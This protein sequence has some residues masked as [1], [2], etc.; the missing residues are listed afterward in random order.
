MRRWYLQPSILVG[1]ATLLAVAGAALAAG[2]LYPDDPLDMVGA[3]FTWPGTEAATPLGTD[4]MGRDL[5]AGLMHGARISLL[6]GLS[7]AFVSLLIGVLVGA[8]A[9]FYGGGIDATLTRIT[10]LF[11]TIPAFLLA[12]ILVAILKPTVVTIVFALGVTSWTSVARLVRGEFA[13]LRERDFVRASIALGAGDLHLIFREILPNAWTPVIVSTA[14]LMA[15]AILSEAGLSFLGLGD[16]NVVSWGSMVGLGRDALRTGWYMTAIPGLAI[17]LTILG[18]N[19]LS[20]A[21]H[22]ALN[23]RL[24][25]SRS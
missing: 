22:G 15:N 2:T 16:P 10:E 24:R 6:V 7:S 19:L 25:R 17:V 9:G 18:L 3:P 8:T 13:T 11:Q 4:L 14:L 1:G 20:D 21:L 5:L 23:P 12:I